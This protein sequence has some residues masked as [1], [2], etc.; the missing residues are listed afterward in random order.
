MYLP[1]PC[2]IQLAPLPHLHLWRVNLKN[3]YLNRSCQTPSRLALRDILSRYLPYP[4]HKI[5]IYTS[6]TGKPY[7]VSPLHFNVSHTSN[8]ALI[9]VAAAPV[10]VDLELSTRT[11]HNEEKL[12]QR[13]G[14]GGESVLNGWVTKEAVLKWKGTGIAGGMKGVI[15]GND[16]KVQGGGWIQPVGWEGVEAVVCMQVKPKVSKWEW[17]PREHGEQTGDTFLAGGEV[18]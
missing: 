17:F 16:G 2:T 3:P 1:A 14:P 13:I 12:R 11:V 5:P 9:A 18:K 10:G 4:P 7:T 8:L 6:L 15:W